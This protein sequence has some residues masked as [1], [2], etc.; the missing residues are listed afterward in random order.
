VEL[1]D[2]EEFSGA[3]FRIAIPQKRAQTQR[4]LAANA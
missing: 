1:L 4:K 3:H 2:S